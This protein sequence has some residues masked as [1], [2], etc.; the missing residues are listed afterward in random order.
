MVHWQAKALAA[1]L[2]AVRDGRPSADWLREVKREPGPGYGSPIR[3]KDST[4]HFVE[5]EHWQY[6]KGL[7]RTVKRLAGGD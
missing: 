4:R 3:Y 1:F 6:R 7:E 2:R 5:V